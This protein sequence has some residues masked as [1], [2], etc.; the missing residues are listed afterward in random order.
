MS[1][2]LLFVLLVI[3]DLVVIT[4]GVF[5]FR[6]KVPVLCFHQIVEKPGKRQYWALNYQQFQWV[7][8]YL[9]QENY[10]FLVPGEKYSP[11]ENS[12]MLTFD[13][14]TLDHLHYVM[15]RLK[16]DRIKATFYWVTD[17]LDTLSKGDKQ[18]LKGFSEFHHFGSHS[19]GWEPLVKNG[20]ENYPPQELLA[21]IVDSKKV[22]EKFLEKSV[23]SF[24]YPQGEWSDT[25]HNVV[26]KHYSHVFSVDY[27]FYGSD[28]N[29]PHGR[30]LI[31]NNSDWKQE[32]LI[33]LKR[34]KPM[35][36]DWFSGLIFFVIGFNFLTILRLMKLKEKSIEI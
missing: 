33:Y 8:D 19:K 16:S 15:P 20:K 23:N 31:A 24:A 1:R 30:L 9:K 5:I 12:V 28:Q 22:L 14:G 21:Q 29:I 35:E 26:R 6:P 3:V 4:Y 10:R 17:M 36:S 7:M 18:K 13:D 11:W 2:R 34:S 27:G 25:L 32:L